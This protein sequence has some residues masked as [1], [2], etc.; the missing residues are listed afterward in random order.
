MVCNDGTITINRMIE[1]YFLSKNLQFCG[2]GMYLVASA[3]S[4]E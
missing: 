1:F 2:R 4:V 3:L